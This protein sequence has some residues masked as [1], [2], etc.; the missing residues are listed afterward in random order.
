MRESWAATRRKA[1]ADLV[2]EYGW[3]ATSSWCTTISVTGHTFCVVR[4]TCRRP[5][6]R[7]DVLDD[8]QQA[9][10]RSELIEPLHASDQVHK[11]QALSLGSLITV[12]TERRIGR[13]PDFTCCF[14]NSRASVRRC[15][16]SRRAV[17]ETLKPVSASVSSMR[18]YSSVLIELERF[19]SSTSALPTARPKAAS[20]RRCS[21]ASRG[22]G[23]RRA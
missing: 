14:P 21:T 7:K 22:S 15:I 17:S 11:P 3:F 19:V 9:N 5:R 1:P 18:S 13:R 20:M 10:C 16:P 23:R 6:Y 4:F 8:V 2:L 12:R